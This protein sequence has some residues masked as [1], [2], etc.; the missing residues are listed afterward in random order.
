MYCNYVR[1]TWTKSLEFREAK[2]LH[3]MTVSANNSLSLLISLY[4]DHS[5]HCRLHFWLPISFRIFHICQ[6]TSATMYKG[7]CEAVKGFLWLETHCSLLSPKTQK[8]KSFYQ[9]NATVNWYRQQ[10]QQGQTSKWVSSLGK[11]STWRNC[12]KTGCSTA[13][14][15]Y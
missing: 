11:H 8:G 7:N 2:F 1:N 6:F 4:F 14:T 9:A 3:S 15:R 10:N 5:R 13:G 12:Y